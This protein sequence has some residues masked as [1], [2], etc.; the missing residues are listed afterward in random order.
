M[1]FNVVTLPAWLMVLVLMVLVAGCHSPLIISAMAVAT[2]IVASAH[3]CA[4]CRRFDRR[5]RFLTAPLRLSPPAVALAVTFAFA[6]TVAVAFAVTVTVAVVVAVVSSI[7]SV[8]EVSF[9][10][11]DVVGHPVW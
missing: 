11:G 6:V 2:S 5:L 7:V 4:C 3:I 10:R 9:R 8:S 1:E